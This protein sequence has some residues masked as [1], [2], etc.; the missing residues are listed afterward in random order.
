LLLALAVAGLAA[1]LA[2]PARAQAP[3]ASPTSAAS[4][5]PSNPWYTMDADGS[6]TVDFYF[7]HSLTCPHCQAARPFIEQMAA[8]T[9]WLRLHEFEVSQSQE[10]AD[11]FSRMAASVGE[12][13]SGV[14][15]YFY[16]GGMV[17]GFDTAEGMGV[18]LRDSVNTC[19]DYLQTEIA[20]AAAAAPAATEAAATEAAATEAAAT[21]AAAVAE[22]VAA[23]EAESGAEAIPAEPAEQAAAFPGAAQVAGV[24]PAVTLPW[25]GEVTAE[26]AAGTSLPLL[27]V[28]IAGLDAFNPCAFFVLMFLLSLMVHAGSRARML[29]IGAVFVLI[30][31][32]VY[33]LF[34]AAWLN[35]FL[36]LGELRVI[37]LVA[38]LIA[39]VMAVINIKDFFWYKQGVS[40]SIPESAKPGLYQRM[41]RVVGAGSMPAML[42]STVVLALAA[43]SYELLCTS[44]FPMV[45][46][47]AL[48]LHD[49]P[50]AT[51]YAYLALYNLV[52]IVP[53]LVIVTVFAVRFGA[54]KLTE[55]EGRVLKLL[56]GLMMLMLGL[57]LVIAPAQ[58]NSPLTAV[59]LLAA[60]IV[61]TW[62]IV[63]IDK[64]RHPDAPPRPG[65]PK[66]QRP[67]HPAAK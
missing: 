39:V 1:L 5:G 25:L 46:T 41:R 17:V 6:V 38:G 55:R 28:V 43:N 24:A 19:R 31:G 62:V 58:L 9:P 34:M 3:I 7:F 29:L 44:G 36:L 53:L 13:V 27:T 2:A 30:S 66:P 4:V 23:A 50:T 14:P 63:L 32:L 54:H 8:E 59:L 47:R 45:Y 65:G 20:G 37:T 42:A 57:L 51:F 22:A 26:S 33:F 64:R 10:N 52:Y 16:C 18:A 67:V 21:E 35:V 15:A 56:S 11:R 61:A 40:L 12:Q 60:A 49:L 48:T